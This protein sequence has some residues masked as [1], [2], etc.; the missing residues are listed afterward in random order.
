MSM[1]QV[2]SKEHYNKDKLM[3]M[4]LF[5]G[6]HYYLEAAA[7]MLKCEYKTASQKI[8]RGRLSH[9]DTINLCQG[10]K[11]T[12]REYCEIFMDGVFEDKKSGE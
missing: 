5:K 7:E 8:V 2:I 11:L 3:A 4:F 1:K 6:Y 9:E 12:P 10:L